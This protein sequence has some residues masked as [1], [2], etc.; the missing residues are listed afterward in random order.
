M[1][2]NT[3]DKILE[4]RQL[5]GGDAEQEEENPF[6][7]ALLGEGMQENFLELRFRN[8]LK[9]CFSYSDL[10]W[11][12]HDPDSG[13]LDMEFGSFLVTLKGRGLGERL[14]HAIKSKRAAWVREADSDFQDNEKN[15]I[16]ISEIAITPPEGFGEEE[17]S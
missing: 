6:F 8:G 2:K 14:F 10:V 13:F 9:T 1:G 7:S 3:I 5:K 15:E 17:E 16:Y 4:Q 12:N 11:F